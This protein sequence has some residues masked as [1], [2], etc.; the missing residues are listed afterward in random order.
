MSEEKRRDRC[1]CGKWIVWEPHILD[2]VTCKQ[3]GTVYNVEC[4]SVLVYWLEEK[5]TTPRPYR[6]EAK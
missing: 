1:K 6:T 5:V 4:N 3:C 2:K